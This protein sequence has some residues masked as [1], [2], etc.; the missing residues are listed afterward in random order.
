MKIYDSYYTIEDQIW[1]HHVDFITK[2]Y[3]CLTYKELFY[4]WTWRSGT[5]V[6]RFRYDPVP[7]TGNRSRRCSFGCHYKTPKTTQEK[8]QSFSC[9]RK[10]LRGRRTAVNLPNSWDD[11]PRSDRKVKKS[12][13]KL[14][15]KKQYMKHMIK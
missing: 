6:I 1:K 9:N 2:W 12:W 11:W 13:K 4:T 10:Y 5:T 14:K 3:E 8:R 15:I 7:W